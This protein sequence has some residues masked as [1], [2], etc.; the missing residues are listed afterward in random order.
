MSFEN[1][2]FYDFY[3]LFV[4]WL[5]WLWK[6]AFDIFDLEQTMLDIIIIDSQKEDA[7]EVTVSFHTQKMCVYAN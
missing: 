5:W 2:W 3:G 4:L 7:R 1:V 6:D